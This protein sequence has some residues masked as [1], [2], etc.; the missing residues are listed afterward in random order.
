MT[1]KELLEMAAK[2]AEMKIFVWGKK[3]SEN[4]CIKNNDGTPGNRWNPLTDDGDAA[5]LIV[6]V[7]GLFKDRFRE[8]LAIEN[9]QCQRDYQKAFRIATTKYASE[10][11]KEMP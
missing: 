11:G 5:R 6:A 7:N 4:Y 9:D 1:D 10:I 8:L 3:G 2:A